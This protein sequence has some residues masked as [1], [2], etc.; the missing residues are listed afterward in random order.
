M[1]SVATWCITY[2][3]SSVLGVGGRLAEAEQVVRETG[4]RFSTSPVAA[5]RAA[6]IAGVAAIVGGSP[7]PLTPKGAPASGTSTNAV[8]TGGTSS[9]VGIR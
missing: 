5:L 7:M 4:T 6:T 2:L 8:T 1:R 3:L 9:A